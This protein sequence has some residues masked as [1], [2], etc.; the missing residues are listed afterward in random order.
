MSVLAQD[1]TLERERFI[2]FVGQRWKHRKGWA[3]RKFNFHGRST[4]VCLSQQQDVPIATQTWQNDV[5]WLHLLSMDNDT[6]NV[7]SG[8]IVKVR[9]TEDDRKWNDALRELLKQVS[10]DDIKAFLALNPS[11]TRCH[12]T[13]R[14]KHAVAPK[15]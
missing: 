6:N 13:N 5:G 4:W 1:D 14:E 10:T 11:A 3:S 15:G 9:H 8:V 12:Q 2:H 7:Y